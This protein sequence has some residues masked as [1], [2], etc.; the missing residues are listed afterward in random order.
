LEAITLIIEA[1]K[2]CADCERL[3]ALAGWDFNLTGDGDPEQIDATAVTPNMFP[4]LGV[5]PGCESWF[6]LYSRYARNT[7]SSLPLLRRQSESLQLT[8]L[9]L[10]FRLFFLI[11]LIWAAECKIVT[12]NHDQS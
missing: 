7:R 12:L 4:L 9:P 2:L 3:E 11:V 6:S 1:R 5:K 8:G 10:S